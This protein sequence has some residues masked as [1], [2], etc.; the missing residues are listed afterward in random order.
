MNAIINAGVVK[1]RTM[2]FRHRFPYYSSLESTDNWLT[3]FAALNNA[4][5]QD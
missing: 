3:A 4:H 1:Y 2:L 5:L